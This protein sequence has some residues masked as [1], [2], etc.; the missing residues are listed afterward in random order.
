MSET[1]FLIPQEEYLKAGVHIGTKY[2][3]AFMQPYIYKIR[4]DGLAVLDVK[5][6]N[7]ALDRAADFLAQYAPEDILVVCRRENGWKPA[8]L[9]AKLTGA[10]VI[11]GRYPP[12][13]LT[14]PN[15]DIFTEPKVV[16]ACD[17]WP[18]RNAVR[19]AQ[20]MGIPVVAFVDTNNT[21]QGISVV[22]PANNKGRKS[23]GVL[24]YVLAREYLKRRGLLQTEEGLQYSLEDFTT[25]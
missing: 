9:F 14:N 24:F 13:M 4:P 16:I 18:D 6:I 15:L 12:G 5:K 21:P 7:E 8:S 19:D 22:I 3:N 1:G 2:K 10:K 17:P 25:D 20:R 11:T 23:L